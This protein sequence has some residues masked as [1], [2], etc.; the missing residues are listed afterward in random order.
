MRKIALSLGLVGALGVGG[1]TAIPKEPHVIQFN[2][3]GSLFEFYELYST[4]RNEGRQVRIDGMC[5]SACTMV[6]GLIPAERICVTPFAI[7]GFHSAYQ[8]TVVGPQHSSEGTRMIW[9]T[10][11]A[12]LQRML[13]DA[14]WKGDPEDHRD[15]PSLNKHPQMIYIRTPELYAVF[16]PCAA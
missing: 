16:R 4:I 6:A 11:P 15:D 8:M 3:G 10:Y 1:Y 7:L 2:P 14:G 12:K 9:Q 13:I 5:M